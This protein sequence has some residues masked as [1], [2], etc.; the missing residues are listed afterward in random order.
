MN[1][2]TKEITTTEERVIVLERGKAIDEGPIPMGFSCC[3]VTFM[4]IRFW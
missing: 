1:K 4:P 3:Y 2:E